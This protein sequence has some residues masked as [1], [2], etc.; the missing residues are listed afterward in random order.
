MIFPI[1]GEKN[2]FK[3]NIYIIFQK[4]METQNTT[5]VPDI[6]TLKELLKS[7]ISIE[8]EISGINNALRE[9]R[10]K[11]KALK[12]T[13]LRTMQANKV[14]QINTQKGAVVDR[15]RKLKEAISAKFMKKCMS[16][17]FQGDEDKTNKIF[18]FVEA[19][20]KEEEKHDLKLQKE[21]DAPI[22]NKP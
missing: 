17:Y 19:K 2:E 20:R 16:E 15:K 14:Q 22:E 21:G 4:Q 9:K 11:S 8:E 6:N 13:I 7:W 1:L 10:R 5:E 18:E 12:D 3:K